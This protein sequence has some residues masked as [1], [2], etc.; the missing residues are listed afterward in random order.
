MDLP[1]ANGA[2]KP[3]SRGLCLVPAPTDTDTGSPMS[4]GMM[5]GAMCCSPAKGGKMVP[6]PLGRAQ[7]RRSH[8][9]VAGGVSGSRQSCSCKE[10]L[11]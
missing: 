5:E 9:G 11:G 10:G 8:D 4:A 7:P 2:G 6:E 3:R 1:A